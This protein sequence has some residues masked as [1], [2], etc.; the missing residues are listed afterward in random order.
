MYVYMISKVLGNFLNQPNRD[1]PL[2]CETFE[3]LQQ[4]ACLT[5]VVGNVAGDKSVLYGCELTNGGSRRGPGYVFIRTKAFPEGEVLYWEGGAIGGGMYVRQ[6]DVR[7]SANGRDYSK[8]YSCRSVA[9]GVGSENYSWADFSELRSLVD[10]RRE[11]EQL[12]KRLAALRPSPLGVVEMWAGREVP[13]GYVLCDGRA[14]R[15]SDYEELAAVLGGAFDSAPDANGNVYKTQEVFFRV[16]DLR[17]RF[18]VGQHD[19]D[20][21]YAAAGMAGGLKSVELRVDEIPSHSHAAW[22]HHTGSPDWRSGGSNSPDNTTMSAST[23]EYQTG[24]SG[25]GRAHENRPPYYV[26]AY[27]MRAR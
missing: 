6:E 23:W 13:E 3:N 4:L 22:M 21:D 7:V 25:G 15:K 2:D 8:A 24:A 14:L 27:I 10:L 20:E 19:I 18:V 17:G 1:F 16:P 26:L 5:A 12:E 11:N 9:P